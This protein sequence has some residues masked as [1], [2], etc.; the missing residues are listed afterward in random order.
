MAS[1]SPR[2]NFSRSASSVSLLMPFQ[3]H[4]GETAPGAAR[5][6]ATRVSRGAPGR[7]RSASPRSGPRRDPGGG[8][9]DGLPGA[10]AARGRDQLAVSLDLEAPPRG[11]P[12]AGRTRRI[13]PDHRARDSGLALHGEKLRGVGRRGL[14][15]R[16]AA[17]LGFK[18]CI[19][20]KAGGGAKISAELTDSGLP[21]DFKI[22][23]VSTLA[24][25][26]EVALH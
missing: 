17:K 26:L 15:S 23:P 16:E 10:E 25:A 2:E 7:T 12:P 9:R 19:V 5:V 22:F 13:P 1:A 8:R 6:Q 14:R 11:V 18:R 21:G 20:P 24:V 4:R 3:G